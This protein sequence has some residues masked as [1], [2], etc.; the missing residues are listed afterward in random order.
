MNLITNLKSRQGGDYF[1]T[2]L[3]LKPLSQNLSE[4]KNISIEFYLNQK[5]KF[6]FKHWKEQI[7][8][9]INVSNSIFLK[10]RNYVVFVNADAMGKSLQG[11]GSAIVFGAVFHAL[12][13]RTKMVDT[14]KDITI[15]MFVCQKFSCR[16]VWKHWIGKPGYITV[17]Y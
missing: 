8:G 6:T 13:Q 16:F 15:I 3:V 14:N 5:K 11:A 4:S 17:C 9:D 1:L 10:G 2:S 7:G 12:V